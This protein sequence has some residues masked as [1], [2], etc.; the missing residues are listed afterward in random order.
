LGRA[1]KLTAHAIAQA[2][3]DG[4]LKR[5]R[6]RQREVIRQFQV[7]ARTGDV[8]M[9]RQALVD[10]DLTGC[11]PGLI[12]AAGRLGSVPA[13]TRDGF[14]WVWADLGDSLRAAAATDLELINALRVLLPPYDGPAL[15]LFRGDG[16]I[17]RR[18]RA[19]GASWT[20]SPE[21]AEAFAVNRSVDYPDGTVLLETEAPAGAIISATWLLHNDYGEFEHVVDRRRLQRVRV[22]KRFPYSPREPDEAPS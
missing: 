13:T 4:R 16:A 19:Y 21:V 17:N 2:D 10:A 15:R 18:R 14:V 8:G 3:W 11:L 22:L 7:G 5:E 9:A 6:S 12:R 1:T 20:T